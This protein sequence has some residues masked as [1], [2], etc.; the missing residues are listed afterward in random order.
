MMI[1]HN[2]PVDTLHHVDRENRAMA[3]VFSYHTTSLPCSSDRNN[4]LTSPPRTGHSLYSPHDIPGSSLIVKLMRLRIAMI[5]QPLI[6]NAPHLFMESR[7]MTPT[8]L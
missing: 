7:R 1:R 5:V 8:Y 4:Q 6:S 3:L 2:D